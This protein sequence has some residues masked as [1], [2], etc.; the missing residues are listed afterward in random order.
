MARLTISPESGSSAAALMAGSESLAGAGYSSR[1]NL[2]TTLSGRSPARPPAR[3]T[4]RASWSPT[5]FY[6]SLIFRPSV[7]RAVGE[8]ELSKM[9]GKGQIFCPG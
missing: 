2:D 3:T 1:Q 9:T 8:E 5:G 6:R 7:W 4:T